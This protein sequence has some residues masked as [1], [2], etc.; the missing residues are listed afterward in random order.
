MEN[1]ETRVQPI[2]LTDNDT[3][4]TYE[5]DFNRDAIRFAEAR[6]FRIEDVVDYPNTKVPELFYYAFRMHHKN[7]ARAQT[8]DILKKLGG[9]TSAMIERLFL[10]FEQA[11]MAD[12]IQPDEDMG[13]NSR[14]TVEL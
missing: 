1:N 11:A 5:L 9:L 2:R 3:G 7:L 8:D 4:V 6:Q 13:K 12:T 14:M 10:L